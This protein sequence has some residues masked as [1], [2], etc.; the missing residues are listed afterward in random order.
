MTRRRRCTEQR[1]GYSV[2]T[3]TIE[4]S[5]AALLVSS[6]FFKIISYVLMHSSKGGLAPSLGNIY[7]L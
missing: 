6:P 5:R 2:P 1:D 4:Q 7:Q 3:T